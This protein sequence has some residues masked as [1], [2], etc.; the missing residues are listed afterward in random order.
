[1]TVANLVLDYVKVLVWPVVI[2]CVLIG[3]RYPLQRLIARL[4]KVDAVGVSATFEAAAQQA[5]AISGHPSKGIDNVDL[6][7]IERIAPS[8]Y[9]DA[10][11]LA[12]KFRSGKIVLLDLT[13]TP[14]ADAKRLLDFSAGIAFQSFGTMDK[15]ASRVFLLHGQRS[16]APSEQ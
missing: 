10:R 9:K 15:V 13:E 12:E 1:M 8:G 5:T 7:K 3:Y 14:N 11:Q 2:G 16:S 6:T 4:T